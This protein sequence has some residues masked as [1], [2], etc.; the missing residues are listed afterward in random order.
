MRLQQ[1][2]QNTLPEIRKHYEAT[3][4]MP[5]GYNKYKVGQM[6]WWSGATLLITSF[7]DEVSDDG[8]YNG[9]VYYLYQGQEYSAWL[10]DFQ[11][12]AI[13]LFCEGVL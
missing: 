5:D 11:Q 3:G 12:E 13:P 8:F 10:G 9:R 7:T 1:A 4:Y 2:L 6:V